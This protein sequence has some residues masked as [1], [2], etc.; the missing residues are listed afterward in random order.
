MERVSSRLLGSHG[1]HPSR[2]VLPPQLSKYSQSNQLDSQALGAVSNHLPNLNFKSI[3]NILHSQP[4]KVLK[5]GGAGLIPV[6]N[7]PSVDTVSNILNSSQMPLFPES[8]SC[9]LRQWQFKGD[10]KTNFHRNVYDSEQHKRVEMQ[11]IYQVQQLAQ[12]TISAQQNS[13]RKHNSPFF[14][15]ELIW[16]S[17]LII[18][19]SSSW[20]E[21]IK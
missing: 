14:K 5:C 17:Y 6:L 11:Q 8:L 9:T 13:P 12:C 7:L 21:T 15:S 20:T 4:E 16:S 1:A 3:F 10:T 19:P 2:K 18:S